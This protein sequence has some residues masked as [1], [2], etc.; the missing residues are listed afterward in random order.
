MLLGSR[1]FFI[2]FGNAMTDM[3]LSWEMPSIV[4]ASYIFQ[5]HSFAIVDVQK[6]EPA[7]CN[8][9]SGPH[10]ALDSKFTSFRQACVMPY[11]RHIRRLPQVSWLR[12][13]NA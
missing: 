7:D 8:K 3:V 4:R 10:Y 9:L 1:C 6:S 12:R 11:E 2:A 13:C 5:I